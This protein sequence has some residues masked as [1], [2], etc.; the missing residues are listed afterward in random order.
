MVEGY[1]VDTHPL[2][3]YAGNDLKRLS[4]RARAA[5]EAAESGEGFL[6]V[7]APVVL[8]TWLLALNGTIRLQTTLA[9]W[10]EDLAASGF[11]PLDM[12][13]DDILDAAALRWSHRDIFDRLIVAT[14]QRMDLPLLTKDHAIT[15]WAGVSG[16][17]EVVW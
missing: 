17:I 9:A 12:T 15:E 14:A 1:V 3:F 10:W 2:L 8:E 11:H 16:A 13:R 5:F 7:P 6:Y 4:K